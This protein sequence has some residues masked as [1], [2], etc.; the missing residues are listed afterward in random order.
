MKLLDFWFFVT[1]LSLQSLVTSSP[2]SNNAVE[3]LDDRGLFS[4]IFETLA[5]TILKDI[6]NAADCAGCQV[7]KPTCIYQSLIP[8]DSQ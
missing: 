7:R 5:K 3:E 6:E 2:L 8:T 1:L 4:G